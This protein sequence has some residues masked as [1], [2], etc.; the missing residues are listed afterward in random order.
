MD[1]LKHAS[2]PA[3]AYMA[4]SGSTDI[5]A[6]VALVAGAVMPDLDALGREH[7]SYLHSLVFVIP[8]TLAALASRNTYAILFTAGVWFHLFLDA[9]TGVI[10]FIYPFRRIGYGIKVRIKVGSSGLGVEIKLVKAYPTPRR[11]YN[12]DVGGGMVILIIAVAVLIVKLIR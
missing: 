9:F 7:R 4:I 1:P 6:I 3:L 8:L 12:V 2:I 11:E 10:P 5:T